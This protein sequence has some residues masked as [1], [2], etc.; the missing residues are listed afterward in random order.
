MM[1]AWQ[2]SSG[3]DT[4]SVYLQIT[5]RLFLVTAPWL[6]E[7]THL[8]I[9]HNVFDSMYQIYRHSYIHWITMAQLNSFSY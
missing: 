9:S 1:M 5:Q 8:E 4:S 7:Y 3:K 6:F 2:P